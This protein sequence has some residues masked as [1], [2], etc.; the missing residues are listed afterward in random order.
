MF[1]VIKRVGHLTFRIDLSSA[2]EIHS[3]IDAQH[4]KPSL[5]RAIDEGLQGSGEHE[6]TQDA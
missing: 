2:W 6:P 3:V 4:W 1:K 5:P